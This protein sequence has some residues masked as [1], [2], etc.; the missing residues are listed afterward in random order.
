MK[1]EISEDVLKKTHR[2]EKEFFCMSDER[3]DL[4]QVESSS[5]YQTLFVK[6][7]SDEECC[8]RTPIANDLVCYCPTRNEIYNKYH[9]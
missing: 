9:I 4:C 7:L 6:C 5:G 2:C 8:Y 3:K 1:L